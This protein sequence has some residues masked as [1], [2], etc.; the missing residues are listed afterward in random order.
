MKPVRFVL[1]NIDENF[2]ISLI[3]IP[4]NQTGSVKTKN[5]IPY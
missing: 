4:K 1:D 3:I 5:E 2:I